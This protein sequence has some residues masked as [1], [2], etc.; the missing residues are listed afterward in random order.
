MKRKEFL[1]KTLQTGLYSGAFILGNNTAQAQS[2]SSNN[3]GNSAYKNE[4]IPKVVRAMLAMQRRA[5]EQGV[6][7]Q[8]LL[9]LG[10]T[11]LVVLFAKDALVNQTKDGMLGVTKYQTKHKP[12]NGEYIPC[13]KS[14]ILITTKALS[15][16][17]LAKS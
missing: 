10:E 4:K 9:E 13:T 11:E 16:N 15:V 14:V 3:K 8:A 6:A 2:L 7:S 1:S 5:W 17:Y 12:R